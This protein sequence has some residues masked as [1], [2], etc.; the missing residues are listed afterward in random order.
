MHFC[1]KAI[2]HVGLRR[3]GTTSYCT[4]VNDQ[5]GQ[6]FKFESISLSRTHQAEPVD[7]EFEGAISNVRG[8]VS[9]PP[10]D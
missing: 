9:S 4:P 6:T 5:V 3:H 8:E 2:L 1:L 10:A 7:E